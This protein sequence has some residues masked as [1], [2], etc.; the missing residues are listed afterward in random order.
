GMPTLSATM[1][2]IDP[3]GNTSSSVS[4]INDLSLKL[5]S[6]TGV[7]YW[8][9]NGLNDSNFNTPGGVSNTIDTV[10]NVFLQ[11]PEIGTWT[12][13]VIA[14]QVVQDAWPARSPNGATD[15]AFSLVVTRGLVPP[16][17]CYAN[18]DGSQV[19][20]CLNVNDFTCFL[21]HFAAGDSYANC[22]GSTTFPVLN[23]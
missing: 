3:M 15:A 21:N 13:Q 22:D 14:T 1:C 7:I 4:R 8:G 11:G 19:Q 16:A 6:P 23:V 9:N 5:T 2:Y 17:P 10:E 12:V 18:C 20:P